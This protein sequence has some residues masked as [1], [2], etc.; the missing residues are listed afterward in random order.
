M[1]FQIEELRR[2]KASVNQ[3]L[4]DLEERRSRLH[5][6][7]TGYSS[8][9][10]QLQ[11]EYEK[12][13]NELQKLKLNIQNTKLEQAEIAQRNLPDIKAPKRILPSNIV[14]DDSKNWMQGRSQKNACTL[15][16]CFDY[17]RCSLTSHFPVYF[18]TPEQFAL[19]QGIKLDSFIRDSVNHAFGYS[20]HLTY[21][22]QTAC[23]YV[24]LIGDIASGGTVQ[25]KI[26]EN[27]LKKLPYWH[28][29]GRNHILLHVS[30]RLQGANNVLDPLDS[31]DIGRAMV[32]RSFYSSVV[33]Y[34]TEFDIII[35][36]SLGI[37]HGEVWSDL[38]MITPAR[39]KHSFSFQGEFQ[40]PST[41]HSNAEDNV[42]NQGDISNS[43]RHSEREKE[44]LLASQERAI[45]ETAKH[46]QTSYPD[47]NF[48]FEFSCTYERVVG[49]SGEWEMCG[50]DSERQN[51]L[52]QSTF[53]LIM[54]PTNVSS[55]TGQR[56]TPT[57]TLLFQTRFYEALK[58]G[59][60]PVILGGDYNTL[61]YSDMI[62]WRHAVLVIPRARV[63][64]LHYYIRSFT[65]MDILAMRRHGRQLWQTYLGST[66]SIV[67]SVLTN[68]RTRLQI[69]A[70]PARE[71]PSPSIFNDTFRPLVAADIPDP[72]PETDDN[73]G[74]IESPFPSPTYLHNFTYAPW[75]YTGDT[76]PHHMYPSTPFEEVMPGEAKFVGKNILA[77]EEKL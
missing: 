51:L 69:P 71:E 21:D 55:V 52:E 75:M 25:A 43:H 1:Q 60:I 26:L 35:P 56:Y 67:D 73:L 74:P 4:R 36:P 11:S 28:G 38:P 22:P 53:T 33:S 12:T 8:H 54:A 61:P 65:D 47:L 16:S 17:S 19:P 45:V 18:Y 70:F 42:P 2:I 39:R 23:V 72:V 15:H 68:V 64:E 49:M 27:Y 44:E 63:T 66:R 50:P 40:L 37:S 31:V 62:N 9:I 57:A 14:E 29:D 41:K 20:P 5:R 24:V 30:R 77:I 13:A 6:E 3:E 58:Y 10:Q 59:A 46:M 32:A 34:R 76:D 48:H 7:V